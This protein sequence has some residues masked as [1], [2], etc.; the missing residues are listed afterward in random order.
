QLEGEES[1]SARAD[2]KGR[3]HNDNFQLAGSCTKFSPDENVKQKELSGYIDED[4][5]QEITL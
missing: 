5:K 4:T 2:S 3:V 1:T